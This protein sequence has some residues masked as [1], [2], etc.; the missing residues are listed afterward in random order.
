MGGH[1]ML[2]IM[3]TGELLLIL[4]VALLLFGGKR[5]P[6]L[7]RS[8]GQGVREFKKA[9]NGLTDEETIDV[10]AEKKPPKDKLD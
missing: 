6:E 9:C 3:G 7:A 8:L 4:T 5:L 1:H 10:T 2:A